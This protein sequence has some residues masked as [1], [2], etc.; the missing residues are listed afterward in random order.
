MVDPDEQGAWTMVNKINNLIEER[1]AL[2]AERDEARK[3]CE[4]AIRERRSLEIKEDD[5]H[6]AYE[7]SLAEVAR[8]REALREANQTIMSTRLV[9][10]EPS[11]GEYRLKWHDSA[12]AAQK[13]SLENVGLRK[14]L[15]YYA[16]T[17]PTAPHPRP[18]ASEI[19][20]FSA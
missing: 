7:R 19:G 16:S 1:D 13:L 11:P 12:V 20:G 5:W 3:A 10:G 6:S 9:S 8:L 14:A 2:V 17:P 18:P 4:K 15:R